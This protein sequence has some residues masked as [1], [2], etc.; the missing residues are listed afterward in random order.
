MGFQTGPEHRVLHVAP[1]VS[2]YSHLEMSSV[3]R[4]SLKRGI[5]TVGCA[6]CVIFPN[7]AACLFH[8]EPW[9]ARAGRVSSA[10]GGK[11][12]TPLLQDCSVLLSAN[13][14]CS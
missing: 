11:Q 4:R 8:G 7:K 13:D 10:P 12:G 1:R 5:I 2:G 6:H 3:A 14:A 9:V